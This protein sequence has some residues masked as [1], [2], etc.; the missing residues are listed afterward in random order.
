MAQF[1]AM[2]A[3]CFLCD[4]EESGDASEDELSDLC[5]DHDEYLDQIEGF[6]DN[7]TFGTDNQIKFNENDIINSEIHSYLHVCL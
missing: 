2:E 3:L 5:E 6:I 1:N 4:D 7:S